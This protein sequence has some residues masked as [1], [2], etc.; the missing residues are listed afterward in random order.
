MIILY[1]NGTVTYKGDRKRERVN[2][3]TC[4]THVFHLVKCLYSLWKGN[5][6]IQERQEGRD[7]YF[8]CNTRV[9]HLAK[10]LYLH[11]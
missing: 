5:S 1:G 9:F 11:G 8:M 3:F 6:K 7:N 4:S 2:N 10:C